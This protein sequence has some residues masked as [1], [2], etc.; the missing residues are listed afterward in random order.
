MEFDDN[1]QHI[2]A[3]KSLDGEVVPLLRK[4]KIMP[5][6]EVCQHKYIQIKERGVCSFTVFQYVIRH[7][8][9]MEN[10]MNYLAKPSETIKTKI[11]DFKL[12]IGGFF[13]ISSLN[14]KVP[15]FLNIFD[16]LSD[17]AGKTC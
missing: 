12:P 15:L 8:F 16:S 2:L 9:Q 1:A 3:M 14:F 17:L 5:E 13:F 10:L 6:V 7:R 11:I 4:V